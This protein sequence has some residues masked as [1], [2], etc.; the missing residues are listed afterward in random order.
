M[1]RPQRGDL[2]AVASERSAGDTP[3]TGGRNR[4]GKIRRWLPLVI[5]IVAMALGYALGGHK[6]LTLSELIRHRD[7]LN[8]LVDAHY[9][10]TA[11]IFCVI[12]V[13]CVALSF[14]GASLLTLAGGLLFGAM[15]AGTMTVVSATLGAVIVFL[16]AASSLGGA[17]KRRAGPATRRLAQGLREDAFNY[18]LFLRLTP[19][20]PFWLVNVVPA[21]VEVPLRTYAL[22]T[23]I[24]ILPGT[25]AYAFLG[26]GLDSLIEAQEMADPGC[27]A[28]GTCSIEVSA[29]ITREMIIAFVAL[30]IVA[31]IP[32]LLKKW[33]RKQAGGEA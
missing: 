14:P 21:L 25:Y 7:E 29:L 30:G 18:L 9:W 11:A 23:F 17:L 26:S 1:Q 15:A 33:R 4:A 2:R 31:L 24:G 3:E 8:A 20:F 32:V 28:R 16:V 5:L 27:V 10:T 22:A 6:Y 12:Y 13:A 19:I